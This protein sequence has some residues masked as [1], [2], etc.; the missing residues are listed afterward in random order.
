MWKL[1]EPSRFLLGDTCTSTTPCSQAQRLSSS[2]MSLSGLAARTQLEPTPQRALAP[3]VVAGWGTGRLV[4]ARQQAAQPCPG[5]GSAV[6]AG[7]FLVPGGAVPHRHGGLRWHPQKQACPTDCG[8]AP[9]ARLRR[10]LL[11]LKLHDALEH[12]GHVAPVLRDAAPT[13][14]RRC[15]W[16][17]IPPH[18]V[19]APCCALR[20]LASTRVADRAL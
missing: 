16:K 3:G 8:M 12:M 19:K 5:S 10:T 18:P 17:M 11:G 14:I 6:C 15:L 20:P 9:R 4:L 1:D 2:P 7:S 13:S